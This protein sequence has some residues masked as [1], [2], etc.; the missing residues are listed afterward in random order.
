MR[1]DAPASDLT[2]EGVAPRGVAALIA[3]REPLLALLRRAVRPRVGVHLALRRLLD[4]VVTDRS[5]CVERVRDLG[6]GDLLEITGGCCVVG[7]DAGEAVGLELGA[8][9]AALG[10]GLVA[11]ARLQEA[12][13]VLDVVPVF[14]GD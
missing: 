10:A 12:K 5:G 1:G 2:G 6:V 14:M 13:E 7:P 9:G 3:G 4:A 11:P 8:D